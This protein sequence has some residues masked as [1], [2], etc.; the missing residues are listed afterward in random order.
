[1]RLRNSSASITAS[2]SNERP[3]IEAYQDAAPPRV[4]AISRSGGIS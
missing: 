2:A 4:T 1:L 3:A